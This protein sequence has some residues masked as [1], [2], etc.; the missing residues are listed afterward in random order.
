MIYGR[1]ALT[2]LIFI[3]FAVNTSFACYIDQWGRQINCNNGNQYNQ[4]NRDN[5][6]DDDHKSNDSW[7]AKSIYNHFKEKIV[8][9]QSDAEVAEEAVRLMTEDEDS[10]FI[11]QTDEPYFRTNTPSK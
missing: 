9:H 10:K 1:M 6:N 2:V 7:S 3:F 8:N 4:D 11:Q 5:F